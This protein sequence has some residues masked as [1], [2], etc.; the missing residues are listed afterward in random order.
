M[1]VLCF[2]GVAAADGSRKHTA[3]GTYYRT[4]HQY[5]FP[6]GS[7]LVPNPVH[8]HIVRHSHTPS[9]LRP[10]L[11]NININKPRSSHANQQERHPQP[12][13]SSPRINISLDNAHQFSL[14]LNTVQD[15]I[16][17]FATLMNMWQQV[18]RRST[19][20]LEQQQNIE[21]TQTI[22]LPNSADSRATNVNRVT[23]GETYE[24]KILVK[25]HELVM[26]DI[27]MSCEILQGDDSFSDIEVLECSDVGSDECPLS[28]EVLRFARR[29]EAPSF[30]LSSPRA[31]KESIRIWEEHC[32][33]AEQ[34]NTVIE[35]C[36][37][38][39]Q[40]DNERDN[41][42]N[43]LHNEPDDGD[44]DKDNKNNEPDSN[45]IL[46]DTHANNETE[47]VD[48]NQMNANENDQLTDNSQPDMH[49]NHETELVDNNV[50]NDDQLTDEV[51]YNNTAELMDDINEDLID[52]TVADVS[53]IDNQITNEQC[54]VS[55]Q[56]SIDIEC[57]N[58]TSP[59][60]NDETTATNS[61]NGN[62]NNEL[63]IDVLFDERELNNNDDPDDD[64][65]D[66][67]VYDDMYD[68][69][70]DVYEALAIDEY[71]P[72]TEDEEFELFD[73]EM[74]GNDTNNNNPHSNLTDNIVSTVTRN[75]YKLEFL[76]D[77]SPTKDMNSDTG[78]DSNR[79][80]NEN[81]LN[82]MIETQRQEQN[83]VK[84]TTEQ[85]IDKTVD[86]SGDHMDELIE[87]VV[88]SVVNSDTDVTPESDDENNTTDVL[89][90]TATSHIE[91]NETKNSGQGESTMT[92]LKNITDLSTEYVSVVSESVDIPKQQ[93]HEQFESVT[94]LLAR[95]IYHYIMQVCVETI[96]NLEF[97][98]I[99]CYHDSRQLFDSLLAIY[100]QFVECFHTEQE[101]NIL[102]QAVYNSVMK[103]LD[104][105]FVLVPSKKTDD[106]YAQVAQNKIDTLEKY[107][108]C[109][110]YVLFD[111]I[112][113]PELQCTH[114]AQNF[115]RYQ[116]NVQC[117]ST[118]EHDM[119]YTLSEA[120][121]E[122]TK[123][124]ER[125][126]EKQNDD[127]ITTFLTQQSDVTGSTK[128][129]IKINEKPSCSYARRRHSIASGAHALPDSPE[130]IRRQSAPARVVVDYGKSLSP[131]LE[132]PRK[133]LYVDME[134]A[135]DDDDDLSTV[136]SMSSQHSDCSSDNIEKNTATAEGDQAFKEYFLEKERAERRLD[137]IMQKLNK[138]LDIMTEPNYRKRDEFDIE[139]YERNVKRSFKKLDKLID[140][141]ERQE[142]FDE[143]RA[144]TYVN[145]ESADSTIILKNNIT[146]LRK[147]NVKTDYAK[148]RVVNRVTITRKDDTAKAG[149]NE[150]EDIDDSD[151]S[152]NSYI[153][154]KTFTLGSEEEDEGDWMGYESAKF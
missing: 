134:H 146:F 128:Y 137:N 98:A 2:S 107:V 6:H 23:N 145:D 35:E 149:K 150:R 114:S 148:A 38:S 142:K 133:S 154:N 57:T 87:Y 138:A 100:D 141:Q 132:E 18:D 20:N 91:E 109:V 10:V 93:L 70:E 89:Y 112:E 48:N 16:T 116:D 130:T 124:D 90:K 15:F 39:E 41:A 45:K 99:H 46:T 75:Y 8:Y 80:H 74:D 105:Q 68:D 11:V 147:D 13:W 123:P 53:N 119:Y 121:E 113:H 44:N 29:I 122:F 65:I 120:S 111:V 7:Y 131:I 63:M 25:Q 47:F 61:N 118:P 140:G 110:V 37:G 1:C 40:D 82:E 115:M 33:M 125:K 101:R 51:I 69:F 86:K 102:R 60:V 126:K 36:L 31:V 139:E 52:R 72:D 103:H 28:E 55:L 59:N 127:G 26:E 30:D 14:S 22:L 58:E 79:P 84:Q 62:D 49:A 4:C 66:D 97:P 92:V 151:V 24:K 135:S 96:A 108:T 42:K 32:N 83:I 129:W 144:S 5:M 50:L 81:V 85:N 95:E 67:D 12:R 9:R 43:E 153:S 77:T 64:I 73:G 78:N 19:E 143:A 17:P 106:I 94:K 76:S 117:H 71:V 21:S 54:T 104:R 56:L 34:T 152:S 27:D 136:Y 88:N 3:I